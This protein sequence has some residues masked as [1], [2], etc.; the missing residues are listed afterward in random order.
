MDGVAGHVVTVFLKMTQGWKAMQYRLRGNVEQMIELEEPARQAAAGGDA[1]GEAS[2]ADASRVVIAGPPSARGGHPGVVRLRAV[3]EDGFDLRFQEWDYRERE[4]D[5]TSH[6]KEGIPYLVMEP[7]RH[8]ASDGSV[9]EVGSFQL[10]GQQ[11]WRRQTFR[12]AF[13][14][15]PKVF[16]TVQSNNGPDAIAVR[17]RQVDTDGFEAALFE[18]EATDGDHL[19]E[20]VGYLAVH[21]PSGEGQVSVHGFAVPYRLQTVEVSDEWTDVG[22]ARL[23]VEEETS[24]DDETDHRA[25][26]VDV[27]ELGGKVFAQIVSNRGPNTAALRQGS[28]LPDE[29]VGILGTGRAVADDSWRT[30]SVLPF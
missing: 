25:E 21:S 17:V 13:P 10:D 15:P 24:S 5:D 23:M 8:E 18:E 14:D 12:S 6:R 9:W 3:G 20:A 27:L 4:H 7:G 29:D 26:T 16:V 28:V 11:D 1:P 19:Q 2:S 30:I 22:A